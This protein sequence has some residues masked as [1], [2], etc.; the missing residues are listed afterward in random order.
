M[1]ISGYENEQAILAELGDRIK[2][3]RVA[4]NYSQA[5][6]AARCGIGLN[7]VKRVEKG[8][9]VNMSNFL[10]IMSAL[11]IAE[12]LN[13]LIPEQ[14]VDFKRLFEHASARKRVSGRR[15][16]TIPTTKKWIWGED[17]NK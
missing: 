15:S 16:K 17:Q 10:K 4:S 3:H 13:L 12:N 11:G 6:F 9:D 1:K 7:T 2:A 8:E 5:E 14:Q